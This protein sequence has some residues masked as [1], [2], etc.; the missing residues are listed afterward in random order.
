MS[1]LAINRFTRL[2]GRANKLR[3]DIGC[4]RLVLQNG[5]SATDYQLPA[6]LKSGIP[7]SQALADLHDGMVALCGA[8]PAGKRTLEITLSDALV[9][10]WIIERLPGLASPQEIEALANDQMLRLFDGDS[11]DSARWVIRVDATPF[12][13]YWPAIALPKALLDLFCEVTA[14]CGWRLAKVETRFVRRFNDW[15]ANPFSRPKQVVYC[16]DTSDGLTIGIRNAQQW[17]A[18][19]T[20]PPLSMLGTDVSAMLRRDC[21]A[22]GLRLDDCRVV[23]LHWPVMEQAS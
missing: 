8:L 5:Q 2:F 9:R 16:L 23:A 4:S 13:G 21:R 14:A 17:Q 18:L 1:R 11:A 12:V 7:A 15:R 19:R 3:L 6:P 22:A 10:S 20:H